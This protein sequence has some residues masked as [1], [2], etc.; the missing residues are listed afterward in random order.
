MTINNLI[1]KLEELKSKYG[2]LTIFDYNQDNSFYENPKLEFVT[3][4]KEEVE[5]YIL[6]YELES[7]PNEAIVIYS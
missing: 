4:T 5:E 7:F 3:W 6:D 2:D 1:D